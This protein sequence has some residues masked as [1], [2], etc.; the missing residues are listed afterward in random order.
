MKE[1][2]IKKRV[3]DEE[4]KGIIDLVIAGVSQPDY[5]ETPDEPEDGEVPDKVGGVEH[6]KLEEN[7]NTVNQANCGL[8]GAKAAAARLQESNQRVET[9][10]ASVL[11]GSGLELAGAGRGRW[12]PGRPSSG[13]G[14]AGAGPRAPPI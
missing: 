2:K 14:R 13:R 8:D 10:W 6:E 5:D 12:S 4:V 3:R 7:N 1:K 11:G 9:L